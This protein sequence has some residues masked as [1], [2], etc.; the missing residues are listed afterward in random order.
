MEPI[1]LCGAV[2]V[3]FGLWV[4]FEP[5]VMGVVRWISKSK[6]FAEIISPSTVQRPV[7]VRRMPIC[8]AKT[9][10]Y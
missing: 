6:V 10:H 9:F 7:Y 3:I 8:V 5:R 4:E 1:T 2:I